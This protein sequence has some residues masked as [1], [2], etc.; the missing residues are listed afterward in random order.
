L[1]N[2]CTENTGI[3]SCGPIDD[4][5]TIWRQRE[6]KTLTKEELFVA[7]QKK[8]IELHDIKDGDEVKVIRTFSNGE[9]GCTSAFYDEEKYVGNVYTI[10][11]TFTKA[12]DTG[13]NL[14]GGPI[15][16]YFCLEPI[17][18]TYCSACGQRIINK[19]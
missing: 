3:Y 2:F 12:M 7:L 19:K 16:P 15:L 1:R 6:A 4:S 11:D 13:I 9:G 10:L 14:F 8:W 18:D 17:K 5:F